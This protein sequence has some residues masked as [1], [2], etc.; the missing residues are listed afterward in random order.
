MF[1][2]YVFVLNAVVLAIFLG[3]IIYLLSIFLVERFIDLEKVSVYE[4]GFEP[5]E[6]TRNVFEVKFYLVA[7]LFVIFD[8]EVIFLFPWILVYGSVGFFSLVVMFVFL[9]ILG[10]V[11]VYEWLL[12]ALDW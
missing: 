1:F 9:Y 8:L 6:D 3:L 4:C 7:I 5:F 2:D 10:L 12:G 11:F